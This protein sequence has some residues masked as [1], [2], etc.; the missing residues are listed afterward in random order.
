MKLIDCANGKYRLS[1]YDFIPL[2]QGL[3]HNI[4]ICWRRWRWVYDF[5]PLKQGLK[6]IKR[7]TKPNKQKVYDFIPLKQGLKLQINVQILFLMLCLWLYSIKTR[8][9][10]FET[11]VHRYRDNCLWLYSIKTRIETSLLSVS[12]QSRLLFMTLFH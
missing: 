8:I 7:H 6:L 2:K 12:L 1:V 10:T 9:E 3:K 5:I 11:W 4:F